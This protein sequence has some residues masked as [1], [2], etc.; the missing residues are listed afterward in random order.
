[1]SSQP[2]LHQ[3]SAEVQQFG[4]VVQLPIALSYDARMYSCQRL[5]RVLADTQMLYAL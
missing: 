4:T 5:N 2:H 3:R 1:M